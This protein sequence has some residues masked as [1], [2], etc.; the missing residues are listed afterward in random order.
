V[1]FVAA[2][3]SIPAY[4]GELQILREAYTQVYSQALSNYSLEDALNNNSIDYTPFEVSRSNGL[5]G[6]SAYYT[7]VKHYRALVSE[8]APGAYHST[9]S[10]AS[11][12][13]RLT[14]SEVTKYRDLTARC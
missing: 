4:P 2:W 3:E 11:F 1:N 10:I 12:S 7:L 14:E 8:N 13:Y 6:L 5:M 9:I